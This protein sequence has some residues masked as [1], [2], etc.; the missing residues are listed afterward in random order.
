MRRAKSPC[1]GV[2][3]CG[4]PGTISRWGSHGLIEGP[5]QYPKKAFDVYFLSSLGTGTIS[6][7][8]QRVSWLSSLTTIDLNVR[9]RRGFGKDTMTD[10]YCVWLF[11]ESGSSCMSSSIREGELPNMLPSEDRA[12]MSRIWSRRDMDSGALICQ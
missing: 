9:G 6:G 10:Q 4:D 5:Y 8:D 3:T 11:Q 1:C 12:G 7:F 2:D